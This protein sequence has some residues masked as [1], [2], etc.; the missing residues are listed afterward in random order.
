V[1]RAEP[2]YADRLFVAAV[3]LRA[4]VVRRARDG[5]RRGALGA[6]LVR[7]GALFLP[8]SCELID[9]ELIFGF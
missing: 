5:S 9:S 3:Q 4:G 2:C 6:H 1:A 7:R 8:G